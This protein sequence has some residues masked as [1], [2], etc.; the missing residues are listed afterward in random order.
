MKFRA[1]I[2]VVNPEEIFVDPKEVEY[3]LFAK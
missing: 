1:R 3:P 2:N